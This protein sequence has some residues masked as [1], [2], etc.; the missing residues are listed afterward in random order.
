MVLEAFLP[1]NLD[2]TLIIVPRHPER[3][4]EVQTLCKQICNQH[5]KIFSTFKQEWGDVVLVNAM[6]ELNNFYAIAD[7]VILCGSF[8]PIGGHNP[9][10]PAYF[11]APILSGKHIYNQNALF[12]LIEGY[13]LIE[14]KE[15]DQKLKAYKSL[16]HSYIKESE[17]KFDELMALIQS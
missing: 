2:A 6:G 4:D 1:L 16:P 3:F 15:L 17:S 5:N 13:E 7:C 11:H 8:L 9:L 12:S 14:S 10:E